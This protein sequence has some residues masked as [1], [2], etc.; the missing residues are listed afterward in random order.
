M[1]KALL[2]LTFL[3]TAAMVL[4]GCGSSSS[5]STS[6]GKEKIVIGYFP[7]INH[8]PAMVAK[9]KG[10]FEQQLG[11]GTTIEYKT[12]AEGGSFMT[13]LKTGEIDAGLVGPGPAMNNYSTGADVKIIAGASTGGT[14]VLARKGVEINSVEDFAGKT[15]IT[16]G[17][18]CTHDVQYETYLEEQGITSQRI[19]GTMKHLTGQPAQYAAM[20]KAGKVDI[21]V[22]P[23]PWAAVIEKETGAEVVIG[24]DE[25]SFGETLPASVM[26]TSGK[27]IEENPETVQKIIDAHKEAVKFINENPAEAQEITI[28]DIKETTGQELERDVVELAWERIGFTHEVD[29]Q[30]IQD[31]SDSSYALK[32]LK[33]KPEFKTLIDDSYLN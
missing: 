33:D 21:A 22:A 13:A 24:W 8:V 9:D 31:F 16:P 26:V 2:L 27:M 28:K 25:V 19:G 32:F 29:A 3:F 1:K 17:V 11:D 30:A 5:T 20:L 7:N 4:A 18:G 14:V 12:F 10:F 15:F 23:E 6:A